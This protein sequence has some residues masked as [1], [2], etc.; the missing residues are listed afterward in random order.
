M[1]TG[2]ELV[3]WLLIRNLVATRQ[4]G[5]SYGNAL[6]LGRVIEHVHNEH[7]F[8]DASFFY[9]FTGVSETD[10]LEEGHTSS[11]NGNLIS[12]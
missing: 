6:L 4:E 7:Y 3:D 5:V 11:P 2:A 8:H 9:Q 10:G 1:F 12:E